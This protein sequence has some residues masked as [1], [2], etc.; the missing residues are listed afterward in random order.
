MLRGER[1]GLRTRLPGDVPILH[2]DLQ[3][4]VETRARADSRPWQPI[5]ESA[6]PFA[7]GEPREDAAIFSVVDLPSAELAGAA[8]LWGIDS[9]NRVAHLGL[10]LRPAFRG[11]GL[12]TDVVA[13]L[14][15]YG[16]AIRGMHRLQLETLADNAPMIRAAQRAGF[17][18]EGTLREAAW[19]D[20]RFHDEVVLG[21]LGP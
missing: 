20:G 5:P 18:I 13:L 9:H 2:A 14:S 7:I 4:D 6:S 21:R 1:V 8:L 15:H 17:T 10:T 19:V 11:R 3:E 16:F 12:A